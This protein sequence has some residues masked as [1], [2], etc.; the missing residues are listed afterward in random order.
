VDQPIEDAPALE[1][2]RPR[3]REINGYR[4]WA[5]PV[6]DHRRKRKQIGDASDDDGDEMNIHS[7]NVLGRLFGPMF[8]V[9]ARIFRLGKKVS[10]GMEEECS[11]SARGILDA[12]RTAIVNYYLPRVITNPPEAFLGQF[13]SDEPTEEDARKWLIHE[14]DAVFP[15]A[16]Q[17]IKEMELDV[18]YKDLTFEILNR[19]DFL[20][21]VQQAY[22]I[23]DWEKPYKEFRAAGEKRVR[24]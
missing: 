10:H 7:G 11:W 4:Q 22:P 12:S 21:R 13:P 6:G 9:E 8:G 16:E 18:T 1:R 2:R 24:Q 14:L 5:R 15:G 20:S 23:L 17:L 3:D 19:K